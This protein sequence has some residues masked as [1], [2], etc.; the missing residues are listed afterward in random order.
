M[1]DEG[2][3]DT[4][5]TWRVLFLTNHSTEFERRSGIH[6]NINSRI[7]MSSSWVLDGSLFVKRSNLILLRF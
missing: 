6:V 7:W 1:V 3:S 5:T 2:F 4:V